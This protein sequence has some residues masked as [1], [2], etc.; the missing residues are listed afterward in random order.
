MRQYRLL[1]SAERMYI[2]SFIHRMARVARDQCHPMREIARVGINKA[3]WRW[4]A[5]GVD[6]ATGCVK[7]D[8]LK[9]DVE[10][11]PFTRAARQHL[12]TVGTRGLRHEHIVPRDMLARRIIECGMDM[13]AITMLLDRHCIGA[14]ITAEE[15]RRLYPRKA[16]PAGWAWETDDPWARYRAA[17]ICVEAPGYG[18]IPHLANTT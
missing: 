11:L 4:T 5:D 8:V 17:A 6:L 18:S 3:L 10:F 15:D 1:N 14:I 12:A 7:Y 2:V 16:M 13:A 9:Y